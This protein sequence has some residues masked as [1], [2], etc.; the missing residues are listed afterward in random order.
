MRREAKATTRTSNPMA[1]ISFFDA[2]RSCTTTRD[3][4]AP[5]KIGLQIWNQITAEVWVSN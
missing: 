5:D 3:T 4:N 2:C 1:A